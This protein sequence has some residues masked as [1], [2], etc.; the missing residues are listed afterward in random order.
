MKLID[1]YVAEVGRRLPLMMGRADIEKELRSTLQDMLEDRAQKAGRPADET[2]ETELLLEY[3]P[4]DKVA[5]TY[6]PHPYLIGPQMFPFFI[7]IFK[8]VVFGI[9]IGL[10]VVTIIQ[11]ITQMPVV[12]NELVEI[13]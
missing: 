8:I 13:I 2:M 3:G 10:S 12:G 11:V 7:R 1:H 4:P 5:A 9:V 6:N